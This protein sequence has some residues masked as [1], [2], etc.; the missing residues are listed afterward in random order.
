MIKDSSGENEGCHPSAQEAKDHMAALYANEYSTVKE[1]L[2]VENDDFVSLTVGKPIRLFP[3]GKLTRSGKVIE[4]TKELASRMRLPRYT[5]AIKLGSHEDATPAGGFIESLSVGE[6]GLYAMP[7]F[8]EKGAKAILEGD[9]RYHSP[10]VI[11][12]GRLE[13]VV[14]GD[15][16]APLI[17]GL[18]LLH[19]PALGSAA[20]LYHVETSK[21]QE[22]TAEVEKKLDELSQSNKTLLEKLSE[23]FSAKKQEA[24][25]A[26]KF[27]AVSKERDDFAAKLAEIEAKGVKDALRAQVKAEFDTDKF[28][29]AYQGMVM[30]EEDIEMMASLDEEHRAWANGKMRALSAQIDESKLTDEKGKGDEAP[31]EEGAAGVDAKVKAYMAEKKI[32]YVKAVAALS[33]E[34]P[35]L[36]KE[37]K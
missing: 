28:G 14:N 5:P 10:E 26:D 31:V 12:D 36:F 32:D 18:A 11:W 9:F 1:Q 21:E 22:M 34:Q 29:Q 30:S 20:A 27:V 13:D 24:A 7:S 3:F 33:K 8:T 6:D 16:E 37:I 15:L 4:F 17:T 2:F 19:D 35:D 23:W 25:D